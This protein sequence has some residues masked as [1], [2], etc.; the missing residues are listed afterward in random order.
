MSNQRRYFRRL[1]F[2]PKLQRQLRR[3]SKPGRPT[4]A[5]HPPSASLTRKDAESCWMRREVCGLAFK[6]DGVPE[7]ESPDN[8]GGGA[9]IV[10]VVAG[11]MGVHVVALHAPGKILEEKFVIETAASIDNQRVINKRIC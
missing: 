8:S 1:G 9:V 7:L 11:V 5:S 6:S 3:P 10:L 4:C 2:E